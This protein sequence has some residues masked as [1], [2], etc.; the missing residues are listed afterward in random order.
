[1][2]GIQFLKTFAVAI[3][4]VWPMSAYSQEGFEPRWY[5]GVQQRLLV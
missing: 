5:L 2:R 1:M 4:L 3:L